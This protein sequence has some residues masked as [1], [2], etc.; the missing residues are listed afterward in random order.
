VWVSVPGTATKTACS[1]RTE[2]RL[3]RKGLQAYPDPRKDRSR[4]RGEKN[5]YHAM[6]GIRP[7]GRSDP[8]K[9]NS[10]GRPLDG[11]RRTSLPGRRPEAG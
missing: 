6:I 9:E 7:T 10:C 3:N 2:S 1:S 4:A 5:P 8:G 11:S